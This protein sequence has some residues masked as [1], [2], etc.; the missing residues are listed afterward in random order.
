MEQLS[1]NRMMAKIKLGHWVGVRTMQWDLA[2]SSLG[3]SLKGSGSLLGTH[4]KIARRRP[5]DSLGM[6]GVAEE[7]YYFNAHIRLSELNKLENKVKCI[8]K[9]MDSRAMC[10]AAPWYRKGGTSM[11]SLIPCSH[12]GRA[13]VLKGAEEVE[14]A[15]ANSKYQDKAGWQRPRNSLRLVLM[16]LSSR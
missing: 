1:Y 11:E 16:G 14:N 7:L 5:R 12:G 6:I 15:E 9:A 8:Y 3:D 13:L 10:L 2:E 4:R